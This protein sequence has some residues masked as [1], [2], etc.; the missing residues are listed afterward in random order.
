M[1]NMYMNV[2][3]MYHDADRDVQQLLILATE[4]IT[5]RL[6][7]EIGIKPEVTLSMSP[8]AKLQASIN[9]A[10]RTLRLPYVTILQDIRVINRN[11]RN[12]KP[13]ASGICGFCDEGFFLKDLLV[14]DGEL[15]CVDCHQD[16]VGEDPIQVCPVCKEPYD[17]S[18]SGCVCDEP[19]NESD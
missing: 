12:R 17:E 1:V 6:N 13:G 10:R 7:K 11:I 16:H 5:Y 9:K 2:G 15:L 4:Y 18:Y 3:K 8:I 14:Y 19:T